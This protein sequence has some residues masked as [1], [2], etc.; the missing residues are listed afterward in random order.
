MNS[1]RSSVVFAF[2]S[3]CIL[4]NCVAGGA[5]TFE[6]KQ[7]TLE[8]AGK[9]IPINVEIARTE[10]Q[11]AQGLMRRKVVPD[12]TGMLFIF[13]RDQIL[14]FWME[15]TLVPLSIAFISY[16]GRIVEIHD[17]KPL[18]RIQIQSSRS[19]RY[20]LEVPQGW[21]DRVGITVGAQLKLEDSAR[22]L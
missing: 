20:A 1:R 2:F 18:S 9:T 16:D 17:M 15:N 12:G 6:K 19:A 3:T 14:S 5:Q 21:F 7:Y 11:R 10:V 13:E 8:S 22:Q 4:Y